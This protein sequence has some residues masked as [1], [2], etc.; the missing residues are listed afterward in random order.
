MASPFITGYNK[1]FYFNKHTSLDTNKIYVYVTLIVTATK[2]GVGLKGDTFG[3]GRLVEFDFENKFIN[4]YAYG[5]NYDKII[6][7]QTPI[8]F[9]PIING[10]YLLIV[11]KNTAKNT[12]FK[13]VDLNTSLYVEV[14]NQNVG[15]GVDGP[16]ISAIAGSFVVNRFRFVTNE[17]I[18][19]ILEIQ[20]DSFVEGSTI[21]DY[22]IENRYAGKIK[23]KL[24]GSCVISGQ[25]GEYAYGLLNKMETDINRFVSKYVIFAI[26]T[27]DN[28]FAQYTDSITQLI[29]HVK[30]LGSIP[31]LVTITRR[32]DTD[33]LL[34]LRQANAWV[35]NSGYK[36]IDFAKCM[37]LNNDGE[38]QNESLFFDDHIHPNIAGHEK[39]FQQVMID[40]PEIFDTQL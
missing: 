21:A 18:Q 15:S 29:N 13:L 8:P 1:D 37:S 19:S 14:I 9:D 17:P 6:L 28:L 32:L 25:G 5:P 39:M 4:T 22:G 38:T 30:S 2:I 40:I 3:A 11:E 7:V 12:N 26:G 35:K 10:K 20:G 24:N 33:N 31:I 34:F 36:Y 23:T 16:F 27:N